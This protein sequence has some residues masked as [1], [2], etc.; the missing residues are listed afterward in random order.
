MHEYV[1]SWPLAE[2]VDVIDHHSYS[3]GNKIRE[4]VSKQEIPDTPGKR[5]CH[6]QTTGTFV[7]ETTEQVAARGCLPRAASRCGWMLVCILFGTFLVFYINLAIPE[8][9]APTQGSRSLVL[10]VILVQMADSPAQQQT[11][12][13]FL[14]GQ[15]TAHPSDQQTYGAFPVLHRDMDVNISDSGPITAAVLM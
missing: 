4:C 15:E 14:M 9:D 5:H 3:K 12:G 8:S 7:V 11:Y 13:D 1:S 6:C 10:D 2:R